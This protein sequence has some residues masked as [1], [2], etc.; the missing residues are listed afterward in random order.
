M[1]KWTDIATTDGKT[2]EQLWREGWTAGK[3]MAES[4]GRPVRTEDF[5]QNFVHRGGTFWNGYAE[6]VLASNKK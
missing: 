1:P 5:P 3:E 2:Y 6:G 4:L